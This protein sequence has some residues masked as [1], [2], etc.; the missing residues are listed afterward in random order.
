MFSPSR[1]D[2]INGIASILER[3]LGLDRDFRAK[4]LSSRS[5]PLQAK[6]VA[7]ITAVPVPAVILRQ[8]QMHLEVPHLGQS[9]RMERKSSDKLLSCQVSAAYAKLRQLGCEFR[10]LIEQESLLLPLGGVASSLH[11]GSQLVA[12]LLCVWTVR[13]L[14]HTLQVGRF[15]GTGLLVLAIFHTCD[16]SYLSN[17]LVFGS[18]HATIAPGSLTLEAGQVGKT[19]LDKLELLPSFAVVILGLGDVPWPPSVTVTHLTVVCGGCWRSGPLVLAD[20]LYDR[21]HWSKQLGA[22][23]VLVVATRYDRHRQPYPGSWTG[24]KDAGD[25]RDSFHLSQS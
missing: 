4:D 1:V 9:I 2:A 24:E 12:N 19:K 23:A 11:P 13:F 25:M 10:H 8:V 7:D 5:A 3:K 22:F 16:F 6:L 21:S 14:V 17:L 18:P 15:W 20:S